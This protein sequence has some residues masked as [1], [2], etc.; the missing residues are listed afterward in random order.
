MKNNQLI[1]GSGSDEIISF[2]CQAFLEKGDEVI[3]PEFSFLMYR[4]YAQINEAKI[5][6]AKENNLKISI[7]S[8][9]NCITKKQKLYF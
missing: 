6:Y 7:D 2:A 9:L 4:I 8:I 5:I 1:I 3:V